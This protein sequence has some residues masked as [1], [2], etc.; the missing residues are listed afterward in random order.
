[1]VTQATAA[2]AS[3]FATESDS[4]NCPIVP[5]LNTLTSGAATN[6]KLFR[7]PSYLAKHLM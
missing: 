3:V 7:S 2:I 4:P 1:M 6:Q 5:S